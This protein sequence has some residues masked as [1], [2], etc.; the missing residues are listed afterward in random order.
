MNL[1]EARHISALIQAPCLVRLDRAGRALFVTDYERRLEAQQAAQSAHRLTAAGY[2][3]AP[4]GDGMVLVDWP[5]DA[6][7]AW[8]AALPA[9]HYPPGH[10]RA[11]ALCRVLLRHPAPLAQQDAAVLRQALLYARLKQMDALLT[12]MEGAVA[13]SLRRNTAVPHHAARLLHAY[14]LTNA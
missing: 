7:L 13:E 6:Y 12:C 9:P 14:P 5:L 10:S 4:L 3:L 2:T 1:P 11:D 8:Y